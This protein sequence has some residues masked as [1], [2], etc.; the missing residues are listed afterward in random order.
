LIF[1]PP[2][3]LELQLQLELELELQLE[4]WTWT[5]AETAM[6]VCGGKH[7]LAALLRTF[8]WQMF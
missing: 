4:P 8:S 3:Q 5:G 6:I 1:H 7:A 2:S